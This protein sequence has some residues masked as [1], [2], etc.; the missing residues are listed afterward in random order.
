MKTRFLIPALATALTGFAANAQ[1]A[2]NDSYCREFTSPIRVGGVL[3]QGYGTT[4]MQPDGSWQV[5]QQPVAQ[6]YPTG[7]Q[8]SVT[9][10]QYVQAPPVV[11]YVPA[12]YPRPYYRP[13]RPY[14]SP[15][16][17][18]FSWSNWGRNDWHGGGGYRGGDH[19]H[20]GGHGHR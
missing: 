20:G 4:C 19:D 16:S 3:Q 12:Y 15:V 10:V 11:Q 1:Y 6:P 7:Y 9:P 18:S 14:Y 17:L 8:Q 2:S 5:V 13:Y